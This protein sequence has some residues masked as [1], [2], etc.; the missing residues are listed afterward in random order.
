MAWRHAGVFLLRGGGDPS[1]AFGGSWAR[2]TPARGATRRGEDRGVVDGGSPFAWRWWSTD[3]AVM[4]PATW[5]SSLRS[6]GCTKKNKEGLRGCALAREWF[7]KP[8]EEER[9]SGSAG[10]E[11]VGRQNRQLRRAKSTAWGHQWRGEERG[12]R[13]GVEAYL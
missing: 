6:N 11:G 13:E 3:G 1:G 5:C 10:I 2:G 12:N 7:W 9:T 8:R 4:A